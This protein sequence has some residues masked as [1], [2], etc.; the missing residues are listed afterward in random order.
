M[1]RLLVVRVLVVA[2]LLIGLNYLG[3]RWIF[4]LN[5]NAWWLALP[6]VVAETY[7]LIGICLFGLT[8]WRAKAR[9][10]PPAP[11][12]G[13]SVDVFI[14][15]FDEPVEL[16]A[17][18][19]KAAIGIR[20][21]HE[22]WILDDGARPE[23]EETARQLG[24]GYIARDNVGDQ[25]LQAKNG[26]LNDA[27][28]ST[29]GEIVLILDAA[30]LA[31]PGLLDETLGYFADRQVALVQLPQLFEQVAAGDP[32]D[33]QDSIFNGPIQQGKDGWNAAFFCGSNALLRREALM[34]LGVTRYASEVGRGI[35]ST[36]KNADAVLAE[37]RRTEGAESP[38]VQEG[39]RGVSIAVA[40]AQLAIAA[41]TPIVIVT[42][43]LQSRIDEVSREMVAMDLH[44]LAMDL[45]T[46]RRI[47]EAND[48]WT[49]RVDLSGAAE[50][51]ATRELSPL[52]AIKSVRE[53]LRGL[54]VDKST[55]TQPLVPLATISVAED[56][57]TSMRLHSLGWRSVYHSALLAVRVAPDHFGSMLAQRL[58]WAQ[59]S[60]Q[61]LARENP[62]RQQ[63]MSA[64]QRLVYFATL[65]AYLSGFATLIYLAVPVI[66]LCFG[67]LPVSTGA[68]EFLLRFMPFLVATQILFAVTGRG[69][70]A[71]RGQQF[72]FALFPLWLKAFT[73][74]TGNVFFGRRQ[75]PILTPAASSGGVENWRRVRVQT[76]AA[77]VLIGAAVIGLGRLALGF[78]E[79]VG[80]AVN[81][82]W[83]AFDLAILSVLIPAARHRGVQPKEASE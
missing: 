66:F 64:A 68:L 41:G 79:P 72:N 57:A 16:V 48:E 1:N 59:G 67:I 24:V 18:T 4:S 82:L 51:L 46:I 69:V 32:L 78:G 45:E 71:W 35:V 30:E 3:W 38:L 10:A 40:D 70:S 17:R 60:L 11:E 15:T 56:L 76:V 23:M 55:E 43:A 12:P 20:Y 28:M 49:D 75:E 22:T 37:A 80:T 44:V 5:W 39:L 73:T 2:T 8:I 54:G 31:A 33:S 77:A 62:L 9:P 61:V 53:L 6:L 7:S 14:T 13:L 63:G 65:W 36:L 81:L 47:G 27:L 42:H 83:V 19:V 34:Q 21:P 58:R 29:E 26:H 50:I 74:V 25:P 52:A